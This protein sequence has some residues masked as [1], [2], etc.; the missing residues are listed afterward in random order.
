MRVLRRLWIERSEMVV[1]KVETFTE[2]GQVASVVDY[3]NPAR[4]DG[5]LLPRAIR[6]DR[7]ID[8]YSL[9]LRF[10]EWRVNPGLADSSFALNPPPGA[11]RVILKEKGNGDF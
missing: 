4:F 2:S 3:S 9:D 8:G 5:V 7:P 1:V 10:S 11:A 6:L